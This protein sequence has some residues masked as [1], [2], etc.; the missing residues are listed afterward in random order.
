MLRNDTKCKFMFPLTNLA[1]KG[2]RNE[3]VHVKLSHRDNIL[4][5]IDCEQQDKMRL[6]STNT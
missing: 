5:L 4:Q 2:L 6:A 3:H 1:R